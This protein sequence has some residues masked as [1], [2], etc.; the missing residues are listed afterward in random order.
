MIYTRETLK[1]LKAERDRQ[2]H[3]QAVEQFVQQ[4]S[5]SIIV[6]A[7]T[8]DKTEFV[9]SRPIPK[10]EI[11]ADAIKRLQERFVDVSIEYKFQ[12]DIRTGREF[13][14]GVYVDWS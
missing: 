9:C 8:T 11:I 1:A 10:S 4:I 2:I 3:D 12:T 5:Q 13:N 7:Q 14:H 6:T